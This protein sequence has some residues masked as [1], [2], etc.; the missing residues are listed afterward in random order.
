MATLPATSQVQRSGF[1]AFQ[2]RAAP[3]L[4]YQNHWSDGVRSK[5]ENP[6]EAPPV[7]TCPALAVIE[8]ALA[9][10]FPAVD[11]ILPLKVAAPPVPIRNVGVELASAAP[12]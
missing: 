3:P 4:A 1:V 9:V 2:R 8:P 6:P 11:V 7:I 5:K 10:I 12:G